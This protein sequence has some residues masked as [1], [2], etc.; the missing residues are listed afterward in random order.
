MGTSPRGK[1]A[2]QQDGWLWAMSK[3]RSSVHAGVPVGVPGH[4]SWRTA[5]ILWDLY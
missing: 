1:S 5:A 3:G 4:F 2:R